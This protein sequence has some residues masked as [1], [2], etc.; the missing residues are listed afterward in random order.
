MKHRWEC[1]DKDGSS[2]R[3]WSHMHLQGVHR[4][5]ANKYLDLL[6]KINIFKAI[7][8]HINYFDVH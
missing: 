3:C 8:T 2:L 4:F 5:S 1:A 7:A 6:Y